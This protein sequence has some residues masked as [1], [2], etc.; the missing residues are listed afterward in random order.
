M[1]FYDR[2]TI[3]CCDAEKRDKER[4]NISETLKRN[5]YP[6]RVLKKAET[7]KEQR[8]GRSVFNTTVVIPHV[9]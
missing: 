4:K 9:K 8:E 1:F 6:E 7:I 2:A 5:G 3:I